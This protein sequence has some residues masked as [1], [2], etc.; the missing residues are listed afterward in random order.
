MTAR[1]K[2]QTIELPGTH[3]VY[4]SHAPEAAVLIEPA[5]QAAE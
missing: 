1:G 4:V 5:A 2:S 3:A